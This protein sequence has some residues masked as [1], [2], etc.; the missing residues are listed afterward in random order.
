MSAQANPIRV[1][2]V[3]DHPALRVGL[4]T[5]LEAEPDIEVGG[6][7][8]EDGRSAVRLAVTTAPNVVVMS[9]G[10]PHLSGVDATKEIVAQSF[11]VNV[12][13]LSAH[14]DLLLVRH[15]LD[16][17]AKGFSLKRSGAEELVRAVRAV[18][19]GETYLDP[20][21]RGPLGSTGPRPPKAVDAPQVGLSQR[22][23]AVVRLMAEGRTHKEMAEILR[24]SPRTLE[25]YRARAMSKLSLSS[26]ADV[27]RYAL[28]CGWLRE[29]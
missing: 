2:L 25:T 28:R 1:V 14:D 17:G 7:A 26:R 10:L 23:A 12:L 19:A 5:I 27:V 16:A 20:A 24:I 4:R 8:A 18:A 13:A 22:E 21:L 6:E 15:A 29:S 11:G 9:M 3:D